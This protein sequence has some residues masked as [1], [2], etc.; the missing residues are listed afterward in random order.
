MA[1]TMIAPLNSRLDDSHGP[2]HRLCATAR[3]GPNA[4]T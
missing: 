2:R 3:L 4:I 1:M